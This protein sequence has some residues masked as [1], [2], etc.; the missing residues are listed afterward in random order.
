MPGL[1]FRKCQSLS[2]ACERPQFDSKTYTT[3]NARRRRLRK[4]ATAHQVTVRR[5]HLPMAAT[6]WSGAWGGS[7]PNGGAARVVL[8]RLPPRDS[9]LLVVCVPFGPPSG[10]CYGHVDLHA[11]WPSR[12]FLRC[13]VL[14]LYVLPSLPLLRGPREGSRGRA[15]TVQYGTVKA[16]RARTSRSARTVLNLEPARTRK[17]VR[18]VER[19]ERARTFRLPARSPA[20]PRLG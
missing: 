20:R 6:R 18:R 8:R 1:L 19:T 15:G 11:A 5:H 10:L 2:F 9:V 17:C 3:R 4:G 13:A 14:L 16:F 12:T 7:I